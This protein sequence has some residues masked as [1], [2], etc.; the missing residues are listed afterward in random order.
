MQHNVVVKDHDHSGDTSDMHKGAKLTQAN[1]HQSPD[2][3]TATSSLHHTIGTGATQSAAGNHH[4]DYNGNTIDNKPFLLVPNAASRPSSPAIGTTIIE[5]DTGRCRMWVQFPGESTPTWH[6]VPGGVTPIC[7]VRQSAAQ[8]LTNPNGTVVEWRE[9]VEDSFNYFDKNVSLTDVNIHEPGL[10]YVESAIQ[11]DASIVPDIGQVVLCVNNTETTLRQSQFLRG[12][13]F[14][15]GFS[16]T[17]YV[18]GHLRFAA[19]D[20]LTVRVRYTPPGIIGAILALF[21]DG[22]SKVNSRLDLTYL[23]V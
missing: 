15:P 3:D 18:G 6:L 22:P 12:N 14:V 10:Y 5:Q 9:E 2:T 20:V 13:L 7:R 16:Q 8:T 4:H 1:T 23:A 17:V 19:N 21:F 11:W